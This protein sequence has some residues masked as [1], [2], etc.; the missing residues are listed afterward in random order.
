[1]TLLEI[2]KLFGI[3]ITEKNRTQLYVFLRYLYLEENLDKRDYII[4]MELNL[5]RSTITQ[6][7]N[8]PERFNKGFTYLFIKDLYYKRDKKLIEK[9]NFFVRKVNA[10]NKNQVYK[11][12]TLEKLRNEAK[13]KKQK[14][15][16]AKFKRKENLFFVLDKLRGKKTY[17][18]DKVFNTWDDHDWNE[19]YRLIK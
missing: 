11:K 19:F 9:F 6:A 2:K 12:T 5:G 1:M 14:K 13:E 18:N 17:L 4:A 15:A 8:N 10:N 3:D 7:R 16:T